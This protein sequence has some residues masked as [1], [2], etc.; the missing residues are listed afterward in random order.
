MV[1]TCVPEKY[2]EEAREKGL[3]LHQLLTEKAK[4]L[5]PGESGL[6]ALDW[7]NGNRSVL[8]D[9][10]LS[11][12]ML[13]MTLNTKPEEIY[14]ALLEATAFGTRMIIET[15]ES[16]G[17]SVNELFIGGGISEKSP[18]TMQ[19][20]ADITKKPIKIAGS[21]QTPAL[22]S[23]IYGALAAGKSAGGFDSIPEA[24]AVMSKVKDFVYLP[25]RIKR[26][27]MMLYTGS[28]RFCMIILEEGI[29][30]S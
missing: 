16:N 19:L 17:V 15:F 25:T 29:M 10:K 26:K 2:A 24:V 11:G 1:D 5:R 14:L 13:G 30:T 9:G 18:F 3:N 6:V 4:N 7:W 22:S 21:P 12:M 23:A 8:V 20:Y 27:G 28:T